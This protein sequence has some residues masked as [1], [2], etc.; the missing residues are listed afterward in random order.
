[1]RSAQWRWI[2]R[3]RYRTLLGRTAERLHD[4]PDDV[5]PHMLSIAGEHLYHEFKKWDDIAV[6]CLG[7]AKRLD[8]L[9]DTVDAIA[10]GMI[11]LPSKG[12]CILTR[13][14]N[15][16]GGAE[17]ENATTAEWVSAIQHDTYRHIRDE[18]ESVV[19]SQ[20]W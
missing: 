13:E 12:I 3:N 5:R 1:M 4:V 19:R 11:R 16:Q 10:I 9:P 15:M 17:V 7:L 6:G 20:K 2:T 8:P 18:L 14:Y